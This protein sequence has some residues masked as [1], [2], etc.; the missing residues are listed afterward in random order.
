MKGLPRQLLPEFF[1]VFQDLLLPRAIRVR[2][3]FQNARKAGTAVAVF[4]RKISAAENRFS[5]REQE[6]RHRPAAAARH[7]LDGGHVNVVQIRPLLAIHFDAY[8]VVVHQFCDGVVLKRFVLHHVAPMTGRV[9]D[10]EQNQLVF[11]GGA[12][13]RFGTPGIPIHRIV[14]MLE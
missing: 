11:A 6:H 13:K 10:A 7:H 5:G 2:D 4:R 12:F 1:G 9:A 3:G 8:K 14:R